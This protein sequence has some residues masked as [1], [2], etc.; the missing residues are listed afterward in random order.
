MGQFETTLTWKDGWNTV[1]ARHETEEHRRASGM[2]Y[3][4]G[5]WRT[6]CSWGFRGSLSL[7]ALSS[8][9]SSSAKVTFRVLF[10]TKLIKW[11]PKGEDRPQA[12]CVYFLII[13][14]D[15]VSGACSTYGNERKANRVLVGKHTGKGHLVD[16]RINYNR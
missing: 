5:Y 7:K 15:L 8:R 14:L 12:S 2:Q 3:V 6:W 16:L 13:D 1:V 9:S 11:I 10:C 4:P